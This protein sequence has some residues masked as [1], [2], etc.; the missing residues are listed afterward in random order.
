MLAASVL[1]LAWVI[2]IQ[3]GCLAMRTPDRKWAPD[4][5]EK[6]QTK[7]PEFHDV[8]VPDYRTI[9][10]I[11]LSEADSLPLVV[12]VHGS[13]GSADAYLS[14]LADTAL[15]K[16]VRLVS[17]DRPGFGYTSGF[18]KPEGSL[19]RQAE[20]VAAVADQLAPTRPVYLLGHSYGAPVIVR[21][22][23][24]HPNRVAG[25]ILVAGSVDPDL[26][27]HPWWQKAVDKPPLRWLTPKS[28]WTS[29][30][31]I[32]FLEDELRKILPEWAAIQCPVTLIHA[33]ND[34]L[35]PF[36][37]VA[38][39]QKKL[40]NSASV[41]THELDKGDHFILW[42]R[43]ALIRQAILDMAKVQQH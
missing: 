12:L 8:V 42:S 25:L 30:R 34:R 9:H 36:G 3:A 38:F 10:A 1:V 21:Y 29:N 40:V 18:G 35:V 14:Y 5:Q 24:D 16:Y 19:A 22:A 31:E 15:S 17:I 39:A 27:A 41:T 23:M 6:G 33:R 37:N 26:E 32:I 20:A 28:L 13:P 43:R 4:L 7:A 11:S 2:A